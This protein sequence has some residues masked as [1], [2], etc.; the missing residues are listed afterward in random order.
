V[1][2]VALDGR[3]DG[4]RTSLALLH[5]SSHSYTV[6]EGVL[7]QILVRGVP[8][9]EHPPF[10]YSDDANVAFLDQGWQERRFLLVGGEGAWQELHLDRRAAEFLVPAA[11][12][13]DSGHPG[14][15]PWERSALAVGPEN[16]AVL[17]VKPAEDGKGTILRLQE[18]AGRTS[19]ARGQWQ[20]HAFA[21]PLGPWQVKT[22][23]LAI[24]DGV[25]TATETDAL[26]R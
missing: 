25:L 16:I 17:A 10:G 3:L 11:A 4:R 14:R 21:V 18:T 26:E 24:A 1:D 23:R 15:E 20:G 13:L 9:A 19:E 2:W 8:H 22:M 7:R 5:E 6:Q 12:M